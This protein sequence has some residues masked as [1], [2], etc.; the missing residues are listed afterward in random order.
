MTTFSG[1]SRTAGLLCAL[2]LFGVLSLISWLLLAGLE[3]HRRGE[4]RVVGQAFAL[5]LVERFNESLGAVYLL[6]SALDRNSGVVHN[7]E[8]TANDLLRDFPL[9][10]ALQFAPNGVIRYVTPMRGNE[11]IVGHD[12]LV[13]KTRNK[14]VHLAISRRQMAV[15]GP[16]ELRQGGVAIVARF[17]LFVSSGHGVPRFWGLAIGLVDYPAL[18]RNADDGEFERF[19]LTYQL[20]RVPLGE[21]ECQTP[22][23]EVADIPAAAERLRIASSHADWRLAVHR[24]GGWLEP[25]EVGLAVLVVFIGAALGGVLTSSLVANRARLRLADGSSAAS[26]G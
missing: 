1:V 18:L 3:Q 26:F 25:A 2:V 11:V 5:R 16:L 20:C 14:E 12:L 10:R 19:G 13:D 9:V 23:G 17:P 8:E 21:S 15:A 4:A 24:P 22:G 7:F 6:S